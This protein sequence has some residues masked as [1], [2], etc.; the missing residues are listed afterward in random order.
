MST[1]GVDHVARELGTSAEW[2]RRQCRAG[3]FPHHLIARHLRFTDDDLATIL[4]L[5]AVPASPRPTE[6][7]GPPP[8]SRR[9]AVFPAPVVSSGHQ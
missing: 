1:H 8:V 2:V 7:A 6:P 4:E 5:M 3:R 9:Y